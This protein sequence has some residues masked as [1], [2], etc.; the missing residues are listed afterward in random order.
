[1]CNYDI[2]LKHLNSFRRYAYVEGSLYT[3][4]GETYPALLLDGKDLIIGE[5]HEVD[6]E[7]LIKIDELECY[8]GENHIDNEYDKI[9]CPLYDE[10][11]DL[12]DH[13]PVYVFNMR[14]PHNQKILGELITCL[15][16]VCY[17]NE[18]IT[19]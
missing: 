11:H 18:K 1:M 13:L 2:Y 17:I 15:D 3:I 16:Y 12:I 6:D 14:N 5:I 7:T 8:Y 19:I 10:N 4:K 9:I